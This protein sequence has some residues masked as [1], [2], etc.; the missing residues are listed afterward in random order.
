MMS[1]FHSIYDLNPPTVDLT[2]EEPNGEKTDFELNDEYVYLFE[3]YDF[4]ITE[5]EKEE[6]N[7][8]LKYEPKH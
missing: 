4:S 3:D 2:P 6:L 7:S 1:K 8:L 5:T